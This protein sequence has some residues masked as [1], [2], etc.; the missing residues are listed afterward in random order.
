MTH[1]LKTLF[2]ERFVSGLKR[3]SLTTPS[4][5]ATGVRVM[6][7]PFPGPWSFHYHPWL[8]EMHDSKAEMNV[9]QKAAQVGYT[10]TVLNI[11]FFK[12]DVESVDCLYVLPS[13]TPDASDFSAS[14]F[15]SALE[16]SPYLSS[17]FSDV[18]NIG[19]KRAGSTNLYIRGS[20]SR[21]GLKSIPAGFVVLDEVDEMV[22]EN[23]KLAFER[24]AGQKQKQFWLISTP[25][26]NDSG[27]NQFFEQ[28]TKDHFFFNCPHCSRSTELI[29][30][31]CLEITAES[32]FDETINNSYL[33]CREC[34]CKLEHL[35]KPEWL[36]D[37]FWVSECPG[38][39]K[40]GFYINQL[41]APNVTPQAIA[42]AYLESLSN[43]VDEQI[44]WNDKMGLPHTVD[45]AKITE[46]MVEN[47]KGTH[48][49]GLVKSNKIVTMGIDVGKWIHYEIDEWDLDSNSLST[50]L[51]DRARPRVLEINKTQNFET[52]DDKMKEYRVMAAVID[53]HPERRKA[54]EFASRFWGHVKMCF[55]GSGI[56]GKQI[57]KPKEQTDEPTITVDRTSW[58]DLSLGR[59]RNRTITIP[60]NVTFEYA[61]QLKSL[62]RWY[63]KNKEGQPIGKYVKSAADDHYAH[64]RNYAEIALPFALHLTSPQNIKSPI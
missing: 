3:R 45:G 1:E 10:E 29:F 17:L 51:N 9:G 57:S 5:W 50:D 13:K 56:Q 36:K 4:R 48:S 24:T 58:L 2:V 30:P 34:N 49:N 14:R 47:C 54:Y 12:I 6:G 53:A 25:S 21:S 52:L 26:V 40:R 39:E 33:K 41:Y 63:V 64:A 31:D 8:R 23:I 61:K 19:H 22:E 60:G 55:Y 15:D 18:K 62:T 46:Q 20:K 38:R 43:P 37:G 28:T 16:L 7:R 11:V 44:F 32:V 42:K 27:I 59:F 35:C